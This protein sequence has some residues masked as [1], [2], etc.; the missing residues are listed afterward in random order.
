MALDLEGG[1]LPPL[2]IQADWGS[3]CPCMVPASA[4][5]DIMYAK[6]QCIQLA[7]S[8]WEIPWQFIITWSIYSML[9][10]R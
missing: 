3:M 7:R 2:R 8:I 10:K 4:I 9:P 1:T 6:P 5:Y